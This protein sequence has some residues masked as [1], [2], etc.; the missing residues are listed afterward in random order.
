VGV[1]NPKKTTA[2]IDNVGARHASHALPKKVINNRQ[3]SVNNSY[4][5]TMEIINT[6]QKRTVGQFIRTSQS[7]TF[8]EQGKLPPQALEMEAA[9]LGALM[10]E[11]DALTNAIDIVKEHFFYKPENQI[12]FRAISQLFHESQPVDILTVT[13]KLR[14]LGKLEEIGGAYYISQLTNRV[15]STAH[16]EYHARVVAE[17]H[18][19]RELIRTAAD[20]TKNAY[21]ETVDVLDL[22]DKSQEDLLT[23]GEESFRTDYTDMGALV[24][25]VFT[26]VGEARSHEDGISK[27]AV[28]SGFPSLDKYTNGFQKSTLIILAARPAMGKTALALSMARNI[29]IQQKKPIAFFSLEMSAVELVTRL[30]SS[31]TGLSAQ[32]LKTGQ[33]QEYEWT[34]LTTKVDALEKAPIYIDDSPSLNMFELRAKCRRL[35]QKQKIEMVFVDYLQLMQGSA[36]LRGNRVLEV[37]E[38][39]RQLKSLAK[40]LNIPVLA[41]SQ[42]SRNVESRGNAK[43]PQLSDLRD[44]GSI[45]QD[46]DI[47]MFI[48]R[49][50]YYNIT[51]DENGN[52]MLGMA[53][54][55][56]EKHRSGPTGKARLKFIKE[57]AK[58]DNPDYTDTG[59]GTFSQSDN[60][61][62]NSA[63]EGNSFITVQSSLNNMQ[64]DNDSPF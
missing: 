57:F 62:P 59:I 40:E 35:K 28:P 4:L 8:I 50:E 16:T 30:I 14:E 27:N 47:V 13:N 53:D 18:I 25:E 3:M 55:L 11:Q 37:T 19:K 48:H 42:L 12:I 58:F 49:P 61:A 32:K 21:D 43:I 44:S 34:Q 20:I 51:E 7:Q 17:N 29:A 60:I 64:E 39:S 9:V 26:G 46:A 24:R 54:I 33:L 23:I 45:E 56:L 22:L 5:C 10:L 52:S 38:I 1:K 15:T 2:T 63:F 41:L 31:E 36:N 6:N